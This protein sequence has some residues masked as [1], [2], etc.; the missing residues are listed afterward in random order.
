MTDQ[1]DDEFDHDN[2]VESKVGESASGYRNKLSSC[3]L[4]ISCF[5]ILPTSTSEQFSVT[6]SFA[7][8]LLLQIVNCVNLCKI[9]FCY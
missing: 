8:D 2:L 3:F 7:S 6:F 9:N 1:S 4:Y 5:S